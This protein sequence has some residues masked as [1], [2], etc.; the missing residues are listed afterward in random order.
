MLRDCRQE[1][2]T[3]VNVIL[4]YVHAHNVLCV[5]DDNNLVIMVHK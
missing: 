4:L 1:Y 3:L 5:L 2:F